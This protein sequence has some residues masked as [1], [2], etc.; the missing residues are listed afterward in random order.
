MRSPR[1]P[2]RFKSVYNGDTFDR[3]SPLPALCNS[4]DL[5]NPQLPATQTM[6]AVPIET[7]AVTFMVP[8]GQNDFD[9]NYEITFGSNQTR[10]FSVSDGIVHS[11]EVNAEQ[12][13]S[14]PTYRIRVQVTQ[15]M[16]ADYEFDIDG[17]LSD[18][19]R[20][21]NMLVSVGDT[22]TAGQHIGTLPSQ[23]PN[24]LV[25]LQFFELNVGF[26]GVCTLDF[27][28][29][30]VAAQLEALYDSG[31]ERRPSSRADLCP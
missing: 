17:S 8:Y 28:S 9:F 13:L 10:V 1:N 21:S 30:S 31:V 29:P 23:G 18:A 27:F 2:V 6:T 26:L 4:S 5:P 16:T 14:S 12:G 25:H 3:R 20:R 19:D 11:V 24:A 22:V 7:S 15:N